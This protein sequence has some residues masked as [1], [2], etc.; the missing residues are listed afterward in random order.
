MVSNKPPP[1]DADSAES[2]IELRLSLTTIYPED[3]ES[4]VELYYNIRI[5]R[6]VYLSPATQ[7]T[8]NPGG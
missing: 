5:N 1:L 8:I 6:S 7:Y 3:Y 4:M 2:G